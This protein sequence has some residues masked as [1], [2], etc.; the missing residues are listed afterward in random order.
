MFIKQFIQWI[1]NKVIELVG[2]EDDPTEVLNEVHV[3]SNCS[4]RRM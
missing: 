2:V 1:V 4:M 3:L